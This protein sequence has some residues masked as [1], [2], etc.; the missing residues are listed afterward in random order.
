MFY[1]IILRNARRNIKSYLI[2]FITLL[3]IV[4][5]F[6]SFNSISDQKA[7]SNMSSFTGG[8]V[9]QTS[10][11]IQLLSYFIAI[12][13]GVVVI[14][15]NRFL[16]TKRKKELG[17]YILLGL[18]KKKLSFMIVCESLLVGFV[19]VVLG[20]LIGILFSQLLS[21]IALSLFVVDLNQY[22]FV[23]S[24]SALIQTLIIF[25]II[26]LTVLI[27]NV[28]AI[29]KVQLLELFLAE[30]KN[31]KMLQT[32]KLV[33]VIMTFIALALDTVAVC[34]LGNNNTFPKI[35][36]CIVIFIL[37][38]AGTI[39][40]FYALFTVL[41][42]LVQKYQKVYFRGLNA[43][44]FRQVNG[45]IRTNFFS[46]AIVC[47]MLVCTLA[48]LATGISMA[49]TMN[50]SAK[51]FTPYD[52]CV[53]CYT[54][55]KIKKDVYHELAADNFPIKDIT[56][57]YFEFTFYKCDFTYG[58]FLNVEKEDLWDIDQQIEDRKVSCVSLSDY[59][60]YLKFNGKKQIKLDN[61]ECIINCNYKG[62][63]KFVEKRIK[64]NPSLT[65]AG[66][67]LK[68]N[69]RISEEVIYMTSVEN[70]DR[71]TIIVPD[72]ICSGL[73][74]H[75]GV[76]CA[77]FK[78]DVDV[79]NVQSEL[80]SLV[81]RSDRYG[82]TMKSMICDIYFGMQAMESLVYS[83]IGLVCLLICV[84]LLALKQVTEI[85]DNVH[86]YKLLSEIGAGSTLLNHTLAK[87]ILIFFI[88]PL[89]I[90]GL[91]S[92]F[93]IAKVL[94]VIETYL[95]MTLNRNMFGVIAIVVVIYALYYLVTYK[96]CKTIIAGSMYTEKR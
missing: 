49:V 79:K 76:I 34:L 71:G 35:K 54:P 14:Y 39:L 83:Y 92:V 36:I 66:Q 26:Y 95:N 62:T 41:G 19:A 18:P 1:R 51:R 56:K 77:D 80:A 75:E 12:V 33:P 28:L 44:L 37:F 4:C 88:S 84:A 90:A 68:I 73:N 27:F 60:K 53:L 24:S 11:S 46:Q 70:N 21:I 52:M 67:K 25:C 72:N 29:S 50:Q 96:S 2:Y 43:F 17:I 6:Y 45:K 30:R 7:F 47:G 85:T 57:D 13:L 10:K 15:A 58:K 32:G 5:L 42:F 94:R 23:F 9:E 82:Y 55:D 64:Q 78:K 74:K 22:Q 31:Q 87:Q 93:I 69:K 8:L 3:T 63:K 81:E 65:I 20:I 38:T 61:G 59:N 16:L 91:Y 48:F 40:L 89:I 86:R